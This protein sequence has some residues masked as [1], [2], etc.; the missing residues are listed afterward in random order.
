LSLE[1][2]SM[3]HFE[4]RCSPLTW[5][6]CLRS[7]I[8][9]TLNRYSPPPW[10]PANRFRRGGVSFFA[11]HDIHF[12]IA[13]AIEVYIVTANRKHN[14]HIPY[15]RWYKRYSYFEYCSMT[16]EYTEYEYHHPANIITV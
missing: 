12:C 6:D 3:T 1:S 7:L 11:H 5:G 15:I 13:V 10:S 4:S 8:C 14:I 9:A 2:A 16:C